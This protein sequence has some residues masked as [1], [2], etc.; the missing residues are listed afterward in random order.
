MTDV[1]FYGFDFNLLA[2]FPRVISVNFTRNYCGY[3][4]SELHFS[5]TE[6]EIITLLEE[7][8]Y[9]F[10]TMGENSAIVTGWKIGEDIAVFGRT[11]EWLLTKR[12][13]QAFSQTGATA[14]EIARHAVSMAAGDFVVLDNLAGVGTSQSYSIDKVKILYDVVCEVLD[15]QN[16]GF[17]L[18]PD[19]EKKQFLFSVYSG[20]ESLCIISPSNRTAY[21]MTYTVEKQDMVTNSG[22]YEQRFTNM[23]GWDA[24]NNSPSLSDN[25]AANAYTFY[26]ITSDT[27]YQSGSKYYPV[28]RFDY[29]CPKGSYLYSDTP[30]GKWKVT[31]VK[32]DTVWVYLGTSSQSGAKRWDAVLVGT[33]TRDEAL[34]ELSKL[35]REQR[36]ESETKGIEF[37]TDYDLGDIVRVQTEFGDFKKAEKKRVTSVGIYFDIDKS[38]VTPILSRL[39][40]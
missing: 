21:D 39:E 23:G 4:T 18:M 36:T 15:S 16:L 1:L 28:E 17:R 2:D 14:E 33:K 7:N 26:E 29:A 10:F 31:N 20:N 40:E 8:P 25:Q 27:Y 37:G 6:T 22:W 32:P 38:G 11:P 3:G 34:L 13:V 24:Y 5:L 30:D 12:G 9:M 35:K 19:I